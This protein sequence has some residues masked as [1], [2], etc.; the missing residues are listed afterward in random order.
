MAPRLVTV[1]EAA[2][3]LHLSRVSV[4]RLIA[5]G[6]LRKVKLRGATRIRTDDLDALIERNTAR[7]DAESLDAGVVNGSPGPRGAEP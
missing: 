2:A 1:P 3:Y 7:T 6:Q 5:A 4:Y